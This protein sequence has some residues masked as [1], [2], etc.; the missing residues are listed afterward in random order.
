MTKKDVFRYQ[1]NPGVSCRIEGD[2]DAI[3]YNPDSDNTILINHTGIAI[4]QFIRNPRTED[5]IARYLRDFFNNKP[6][7]E[8]LKQDIG[9][10]LT[11]LGEE[12]C[13]KTPVNAS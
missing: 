11:I 2:E 3:L 13:T 6:D 10:F 4:W 1:G 7:P 12:Y 5:E 8:T 9:E